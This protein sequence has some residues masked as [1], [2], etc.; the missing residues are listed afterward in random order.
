[1]KP[2]L[3][4]LLQ[5]WICFLAS[6]VLAQTVSDA[7]PCDSES[8]TVSPRRH[9][10]LF[11]V[12]QRCGRV[13]YEIPPTLLD[14][15]MLIST[16]FRAL[17]E[18]KYDAQTA[19][20][21]AD[22]QM[23]RW[24]RR[25][26]QVHLERITYETRAERERDSMQPDGRVVRDFV[27]RTFDV[28]ADGAGNAPI[29]D[30]T[31]L[32][33]RTCPSASRR[34]SCAGSEWIGL[35]RNARSLIRSRRFRRTSK[36]HSRRLGTP[37]P[38]ILPSNKNP[39]KTLCRLVCDSCFRQVCSCCPNSRCKAVTPTIRVGYFSV[40]FYEYGTGRAGTQV[41]AFIQRYRLEKKDPNAAISEP[42]EPI[43]FY[44]GRE[45]PDR[46]RPYIKQGIEDWQ[47]A[48]EGAGFRN[49]ILARDPPPVQEDG[50]WDPD[51]ARYSVVRWG[52]GQDGLGW[53]LADPRS[54]EIIV[55][56]ALFWDSLLNHLETLYFSQAAPLDAR[57]QRLPL[58]DTVMGP[59]LRYVVA[60]EIG[61]A[62]GLRHNF[63]AHSAYSVEQLRSSQWTQRW[64]TSA[65]IMSYA[66][67][68]YVAQPGDQAY[69]LPRLGPYDHF[70]VEWGYK[71]FPGL[72]ADQEWDALDRLAARQVDEPMLRFGGEDKVAEQDPSIMTG[73]L[74]DDPIEAG[75]LGLRNLDRAT[76][77]LIDAATIRG[78]SYARLAELYAAVLAQRR[79]ELV[80]VAKLVGGVVETRNQGQRGSAPFAPVAPHRQRAAVRFLLNSGF[81][82]PDALLAPDLLLRIGS[83]AVTQDLQIAHQAVLLRLIDPAVFQR[84]AEGGAVLKS[85]DSYV[86]VDLIR[87]LNGGLFSELQRKRPVVDLYR[88][89]LQRTYVHLLAAR[90]RGEALPTSPAEDTDS[91][92]ALE[93]ERTPAHSLRSTHPVDRANLGLRDGP[94][95]SRPS[96]VSRTSFGPHCVRAWPS[97]P[98]R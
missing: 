20:R 81:V 3:V 86:G 95:S 84:M 79:R 2:I 10:G 85:A 76:A 7:G 26:D 57:A 80:A 38:S 21:F 23:V 56:R 82:R 44:V 45:V 30:V 73:V 71:P 39:R 9:V 65:S 13:L 29:I 31:P 87:D 64:G 42:V 41:R 59:L 12:H 98:P 28:L 91:P 36:S 77:M 90:A 93:L 92:V 25:G 68:N 47:G 88:R 16:E 22:A 11:V 4:G 49:A 94:C 19:G 89:D 18:R 43:V 51:D 70:A 78:Q 53:G 67:F 96:R 8:G 97:S 75:R 32:F 52:S 37:I 6:E 63:K 58:P 66:R 62:L 24:V 50:G 17:R 5:L 33:Y 74:A 40:P 61:H 69:L 46:W 48:F 34:S 14:R 83:S 1:M 27:M 35:T 72:S 55:S 54:G 15:P 60:H